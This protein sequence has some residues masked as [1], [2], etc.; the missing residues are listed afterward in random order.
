MIKVLF[1]CLGNICRSPLAEGIF[2][3]QVRIKGLTNQIECD[4]AGTSSYHA[5][6]DPDPRSCSTAQKYEIILDHRA[7]QIIKKDFEAFDYILAMDQ[8]NYD[9]ILKMKVEEH[10]G[11]KVF[12]MRKFDAILK[13]GLDVPD[14]YF[15]GIDG[16]EYV[17]E[18]LL[19]SSENFLNYI[20]K[21]HKLHANQ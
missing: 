19:R 2:K 14:P 4:S 21:E 15:G 10:I 5:G 11:S 17:Y 13:D 8:S 3:N 7:R 6:A 12:L 9:F 18:M 1:V 20:I 16:F